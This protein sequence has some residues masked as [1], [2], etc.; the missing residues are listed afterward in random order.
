MK[1]FESI[2][3]M[4]Q[5]GVKEYMNAYLTSKGYNTINK[6][7]FLYA[8][9]TIPV[10][11]VAHMDTVHKE[12]CKEV[13]YKDGKISSPQG[14]GGDDRCGVY[15]IMNLVKEFDCSVLLCESE[16]IGGIGAG[17]FIKAEYEETDDDGNII[18]KKYIDNLDV[19]YMVE[20]DR[21]GNKDAVY[22]SCD[23]KAFKA[24]VE[25]ATSFKEAGG[26]F[27]DISKLMPAAKLAGVN[28][29]SGYY[30]PH[31]TTEYVVIDEM[32]DIVEEAK[33][34]IKA[35]CVK[36]FEYIA[37]KYEPINLKPYR[38]EHDNFGQ[39]SMF[40]QKP[41]TGRYINDMDTELELEVIFYDENGLENSEVVYGRTKAD[42]WFAFFSKY[43]NRC[44]D[45][46]YD[47]SWT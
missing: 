18:K 5:N 40:D 4:T 30:N 42:C 16:E 6:D 28:L 43:T 10:L 1:S 29:S 19:N 20:F 33:S 23:N 38:F 46:V 35:K 7:G 22:Y 2:C 44:M 37:K 3:K 39:M 15:I 17:K 24:F 34:L 27:S 9:G 47:Y 45:D 26:S 31:T 41:K 25:C 21:R 14:I 32:M 8:K 11:L 36:P 13:V 12:T